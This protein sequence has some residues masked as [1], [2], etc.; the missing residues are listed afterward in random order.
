MVFS[1][2]SIMLKTLL[3]NIQNYLCPLVCAI[4]IFYF[5]AEI[6]CSFSTFNHQVKSF[7]RQS[8][9]R[10]TSK[11]DIYWGMTLIKKIY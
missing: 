9:I 10:D 7:F 6:C 1:V 4:F 5:L 3:N 8:S 11:S 2:Y